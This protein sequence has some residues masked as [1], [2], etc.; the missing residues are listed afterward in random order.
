[1]NDTTFILVKAYLGLVQ[2][3]SRVIRLTNKTT[4]PPNFVEIWD[5]N[6]RKSKYYR[7]CIQT[8]GVAL[9]LNP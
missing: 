4:L 1:M 7:G 9:P 2:P 5:C 3:R 8:R 6:S